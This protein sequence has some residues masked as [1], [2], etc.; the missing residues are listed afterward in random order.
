MIT[1]HHLED[2][3]SQRVLWL[4]EELE[5]DYKII[6]YERDPVTSLA[7]PALYDV[8]PLGKAPVITDDD[9]V[10]AET[11]AIFDYLLQTY[12][13]EGNFHPLTA[14]QEQREHRYWLHYAEGSAMTNLLLKLIFTRL[15]E[16]AP[17]VMRAFVK[18]VADRAQTGFIDPRVSE[19]AAWWNDNLKAT[20]HFVGDS[21]S[22]ADIMM[23]FPIEALRSRA[24][25][26]PW[27]ALS[28]FL[29]RIHARK[30]YKLA[31]EPGGDYAYA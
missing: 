11:G 20:G 25:L 16:R 26:T 30:A 17:W 29:D 28:E 15:P 23:S 7:P 21:L 6:R 8:H 10:V 13:A 12:D 9:I 1:V 19:H 14:S 27:P 31:L 2:S 3:R 5:I 18:G 4:L 22:A 24:D